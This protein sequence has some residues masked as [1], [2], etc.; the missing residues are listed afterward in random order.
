MAETAGATTLSKDESSGGRI[1]SG[2]RSKDAGGK[3]ESSDAISLVTLNIVNGRPTP[4][5]SAELTASKNTLDREGR[6]K[7]IDG[8][9]RAFTEEIRDEVVEDIK[10]ELDTLAE[11]RGGNH[12]D[13]AAFHR[14]MDHPAYQLHKDFFD[15]FTKEKAGSTTGTPTREVNVDLLKEW[16]AT[17]RGLQDAYELALMRSEDIAVNS[18]VLAAMEKKMKHIPQP[19]GIENTDITTHDGLSLRQMARTVKVW[20]E[21]DNVDTTGRRK[22]ALGIFKKKGT[23]GATVVGL[24]IATGGVGGLTIGALGIASGALPPVA[25]GIIRSFRDGGKVSIEASKEVLKIAKTNDPVMQEWSRRMRGLDARHLTIQGKEV[26]VDPAIVR[27]G[28]AGPSMDPDTAL[29]KLVR[30]DEKLRAMQAQMGVPERLQAGMDKQFIRRGHDQDPQR[31]IVSE[32]D[33]L[34][35]LKQELEDGNGNPCQVNISADPLHPDWRDNDPAFFAAYGAALGLH[36]AFDR[37]TMTPDDRINA[38]RHKRDIRVQLAHERHTLNWEKFLESKHDRLPNL[39]DKIDAAKKAEGSGGDSA[40]KIDKKLTLLKADADSFPALSTPFEVFEAS[41]SALEQKERA[42]DRLAAGITGA[43]STNSADIEKAITDILQAGGRVRVKQMILNGRTI[44]SVYDRSFAIDE[45]VRNKMSDWESSHTKPEKPGVPDYDGDKD[46]IAAQKAKYEGDLAK[47]GTDI[48]AYEAEKER[49]KTS[50]EAS[51]EVTILT[52][53]LDADIAKLEE[54]REALEN[55]EREIDKEREKLTSTSPEN[56][57]RTE[58]DR[59]ASEMRSALATVE[60]WDDKPPLVTAYLL[61]RDELSAADSVEEIFK[62]INEANGR[63]SRVGWPEAANKD[64]AN[65]E[66]L[67][68][69]MAEARIEP[70]TDKYKEAIDPN[71]WG[72]TEY[73]LFMMT[74]DEIKAIMDQRK[75]RLGVPVPPNGEIEDLIDLAQERFS[76][77]REAYE[78]L[79]RENE[80]R[81]RELTNER[82]SVTAEGGKSPELATI[83][84]AVGRYAD[85]RTRV[86]LMSQQELVNALDSRTAATVDPNGTRFLAAERENNHSVAFDEIQQMIFDSRNHDQDSVSFRGETGRDAAIRR[87]AELVTEEVLRDR[88]VARFR[89]P[90]WTAAAAP[91]LDTFERHIDVIAA[92]VAAGRITPEEFAEFLTE[93]VI[94]EFMARR[95]DR[96]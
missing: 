91:E 93:D 81:Q 8:E 80:I 18:G 41:R 95:V 79:K 51:R 59:A 87:N 32:D 36:G 22:R 20:G 55:A 43:K 75:D 90:V 3:A 83:D 21:K 15:K 39:Q 70:A 86:S 26:V 64:K 74:R 45:I 85:I 60:G 89:L 67:L 66:L 73:D 9:T 29:A 28:I 7:P 56:T 94:F 35:R 92:E 57:V 71:R 96:L 44:N 58:T 34:T 62:R 16:L 6:K 1:L 24:T 65:R 19:A 40:S 33:V 17:D 78:E 72:L 69:A 84:R 30:E 68:K 38:W 54:F 31:G 5:T 2:L 27:Q 61:S 53:A 14:F 50:V 42:R 12:E 88:L 46:A 49:Y 23:V 63:N 52:K 76:Q 47:Y 4:L 77:R 11:M 37:R 25:A 48:Q 13:Q 82:A 10:T